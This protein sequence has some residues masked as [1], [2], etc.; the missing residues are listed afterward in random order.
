MSLTMPS[1]LPQ[2]EPH[3]HAHMHRMLRV[4]NTWGTRPLALA[5]PGHGAL[6]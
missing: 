4:H 2:R 1:S 6:L 3:C 5:V